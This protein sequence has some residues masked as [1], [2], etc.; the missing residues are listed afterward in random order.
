VVV[1]VAVMHVVQAALD[2]EVHVIPVGHGKGALGMGTACHG[3]AIGGMLGTDGNDILVPVLAVSVMQMPIVDV[4]HVV[5]PAN[6][7]VATARTMDMVM[8]TVG[9]TAIGHDGLLP[10]TG[11]A[12]LTLTRPP[13]A[14]CKGLARSGYDP[15]MMPATL[16]TFPSRLDEA[17]RALYEDQDWATYLAIYH[18]EATVTIGTR[19]LPRSQLTPE[20]FE[21][22]FEEAFLLAQPD[23][24]PARFTCTGGRV[25][26]ADA[27]EAHMVLTIEEAG[28][29]WSG[30]A[31][32]WVRNP[33]DGWFLGG[34]CFVGPDQPVPTLQTLPVF[35]AVE[36]ALLE[37]VL[38]PGRLLLTPL[39]A[40][41]HR[42]RDRRTETFHAL[43]EAR[44]T[45]QNSGHCCSG[46]LA[47][48]LA[49]REGA[50]IM[51]HP[52]GRID[53]RLPSRFLVRGADGHAWQIAAD[54]ER[55]GFH[56]DASCVLHATVG[57]APF[58][59]CTTY[60]IGFTRT[61]EGVRVWSSFTCPTVRGNIG[62]RLEER[63]ANFAERFRLVRDGSEMIPDEIPWVPG[64]PTCAHA[65]LVPWE[66]SL[67]AE[68][69]NDHLP[70]QERLDRIARMVHEPGHPRPDLNASGDR[71]PEGEDGMTPLPLSVDRMMASFLVAR[72]L[73]AC[74][75]VD[76]KWS[77]EVTDPLE[78]HWAI[79][80]IEVGPNH[81]LVTRYLRQLLFRQQHLEQLGA[82][83]HV[84]RTVWIGRAIDQVARFRA[85]VE[86]RLETSDADW[87]AAVDAAERGFLHKTA[88]LEGLWRNPGVRR[89]L[90]SRDAVLLDA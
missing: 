25:V 44:F 89:W 63:Q 71:A 1:A 10:V 45:C 76:T 83:G 9:M 39:D 32:A 70:V 38:E 23:R 43:E 46:G 52:I 31:H 24:P 48:G 28:S 36:V 4:I 17:L 75:P 51:N 53:A 8:D 86:G 18:P 80:D 67:L 78:R 79:A 5:G 77:G 33:D 65:D 60:P 35:I 37:G 29:G 49:D 90:V 74:L 58:T 34:A 21:T 50:A 16:E 66:A 20:L 30:E 12:T 56:H 54:G 22:W 81:D 42:V 2:H 40:S 88:F 61:P 47:V 64:G 19:L 13:G 73:K 14:P 15:Q 41:Y 11:W 55:C 82:V 72:F 57:M 3:P 59:T 7:R 26:E 87:E 27:M 85:A 68:L 84:H 62:E 6:G 69:A